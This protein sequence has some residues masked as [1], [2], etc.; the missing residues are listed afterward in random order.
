MIN[1]V[2][3]S[4]KYHSN[5]VLDDISFYVPKGKMAIIYGVNGAGKTTLI[6]LMINLIESDAGYVEVSANLKSEIGVYLGHEILIEKLTIREYLFLTGI[7]KGMPVTFL[8]IKIK[9]LSEKLNFEKYLDYFISKI[10]LG[11]KTKVLFTA[12]IIN[13]PKF[14]IM[15]EPFLGVDLLTLKVFTT[16]LKDLKDN[17]CTIFI[18][19]NQADFLD[20]IIDKVIILKDSK[21]IIN[22]SLENLNLLNSSQLSDFVIKKLI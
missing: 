9:E 20:D 18:S 6:K 7:L 2:S 10:S 1:V 12:S 22:D 13:G 3:L 11:T 4:K 15:D 19:S 16:I 14:L 5:L 17:G 8:D 21:I